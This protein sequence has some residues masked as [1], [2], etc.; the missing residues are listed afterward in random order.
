[1]ENIMR[2]MIR[3]LVCAALVGCGSA[4]VKY[5]EGGGD[6]EGTDGGND[7]IDIAGTWIDSFGITNTITSESWGW[8]YPGYADM[9]FTI[10]QYD[11]DV[12]VAIVQDGAANDMGD[13][14]WGRF[15]WTY[16][17]DVPY[18][19]MTADGLESED[20]AAGL[21]SIDH[22]NVSANCNGFAWFELMPI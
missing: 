6:P 3:G 9:S 22:A 17:D 20:S 14:L 7:D 11:N 19:C 15:E 5:T 18:Y 12:G 10:T 1:L 4:E 2:T 13:K 8:Q 21:A 16:V